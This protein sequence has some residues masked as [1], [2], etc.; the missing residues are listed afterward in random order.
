MDN[1]NRY[2]SAWGEISARV[3]SR[4]LVQIFHVTFVLTLI[5]A[6][7]SIH[8]K[9]PDNIRD[10]YYIVP[11][12]IPCISLSVAL[13]SRQNDLTIGI[14]SAFCRSI[15]KIEQEKN[16]K[17]PSWHNE[18]Q[19]WQIITLGFRRLSDYAFFLI[20]FLGILPYVIIYFEYLDKNDFSFFS[21]NSFGLYAVLFT[22]LGSW[23]LIWTNKSLRDKY[24]NDYHYVNI[25]GNDMKFLKTAK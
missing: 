8:I 13:W 4:Q 22:A 6:F 21:F 3:Q 9:T 12:I 5:T 25:S 2:Q 16:P 7:T 19:G 1:L 18:E 10:T 23:T 14:L 20:S 11:I 24:L 15:E 17:A